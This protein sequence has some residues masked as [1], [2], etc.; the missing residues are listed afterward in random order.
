MALINSFF[1][2]VI[3]YWVQFE[4]AGES[5]STRENLVCYIIAAS[6]SLVSYTMK[7]LEDIK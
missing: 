2:F 6:F 5:L 4:L 3:T 7:R 1:V